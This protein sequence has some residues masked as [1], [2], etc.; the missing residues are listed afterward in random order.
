MLIAKI[1]DI[2]CIRTQDI[3]PDIPG[4]LTHRSTILDKSYLFTINIFN[5]QNNCLSAHSGSKKF[6]ASF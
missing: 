2:R 1:P 6:L 3:R 4:Y 5:S